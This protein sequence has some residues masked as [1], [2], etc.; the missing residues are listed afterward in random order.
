MAFISYIY[1]MYWRVSQKLILS[2]N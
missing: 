2:S 1:A